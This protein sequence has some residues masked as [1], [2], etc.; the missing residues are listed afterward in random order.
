MK[1]FLL[2]LVIVSPYLGFIILVWLSIPS[3]FTE[4]LKF[5][6]KYSS[7]FSFQSSSCKYWLKRGTAYF[8]M[9]VGK[10]PLIFSS[11]H[12]L[13]SCWF[14]TSFFSLIVISA[15]CGGTLRIL[16][17]F[18]FFFWC[19]SHNYLSW[20][21]KRKYSSGAWNWNNFYFCFLLAAF[22]TFSFP[23]WQLLPLIHYIVLSCQL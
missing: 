7:I 1:Y 21:V 4:S 2:N 14:F 23:L 20:C 19:V 12:L 15:Y 17:S 3:Y 10:N 6:T 16:S 11:T 5:L 8:H 13:V 9:T 18:F 22:Q